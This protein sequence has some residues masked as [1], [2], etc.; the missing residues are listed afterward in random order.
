MRKIRFWDSV[1]LDII[2]H[3]R[4]EQDSA[5]KVFSLEDY[6]TAGDIVFEIHKNNGYGNRCFRSIRQAVNLFYF[7]GGGRFFAF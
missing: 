5:D 1:T 2:S 6:L 7:F 4:V 3:W